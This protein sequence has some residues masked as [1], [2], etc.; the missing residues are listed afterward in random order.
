[1]VSR[2]AKGNH[3]WSFHHDWQNEKGEVIEE[4]PLTIYV[5][6]VELTTIMGTP[7]N[8]DWLAVGLLKNEGFLNSVDEI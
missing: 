6:G 2:G 4:T 8:Q 1:M 3:W 5:N 7:L